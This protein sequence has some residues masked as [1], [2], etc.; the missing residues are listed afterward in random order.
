MGAVTLISHGSYLSDSGAIRAAKSLCRDGELAEVWR[1]DICVFSACPKTKVTL[2]W[3]IGVKA[4]SD[5]PHRPQEEAHS[6]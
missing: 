3:P 2:V 5:Y 1:G 6:S 4:V